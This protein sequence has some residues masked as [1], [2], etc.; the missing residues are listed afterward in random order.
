MRQV[1]SKFKPSLVFL[2]LIILGTPCLTL[3][4][5]SDRNPIVLGIAGHS[6]FGLTNETSRQILYRVS[7]PQFKCNG[8]WAEFLGPAEFIWQGTGQPLLPIPAKAL[9]AGTSSTVAFTRPMQ[10]RKS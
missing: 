2:A 4:L 6:S 7:H 1:I 5:S 3:W 10:D 9:A 8:V